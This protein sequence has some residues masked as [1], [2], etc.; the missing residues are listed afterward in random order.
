MLKFTY[1]VNFCDFSSKGLNSGLMTEQKTRDAK[2]CHVGVTPNF[3]RQCHSTILLTGGDCH[4]F[5]SSQLSL[6]SPLHNTFFTTKTCHLYSYGDIFC[7]WRKNNAFL[8]SFSIVPE[9]FYYT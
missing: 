8:S 2:P 1:T 5:S 3:R 4:A 7:T 9:Q 6:A